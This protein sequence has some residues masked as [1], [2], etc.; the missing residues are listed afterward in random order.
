MSRQVLPIVAIIPGQCFA[1]VQSQ[2]DLADEA[3]F[4]AKPRGR[5]RIVACD[6]GRE[7]TASLA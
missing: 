3:L 6:L 2:V 5:K 7:T 1:L 4:Q